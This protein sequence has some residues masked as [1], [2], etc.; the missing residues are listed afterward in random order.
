MASKNFDNPQRIDLDRS[1]AEIFSDHYQSQ[2]DS[3]GL[4]SWEDM[5]DSEKQNFTDIDDFEDE[6]M[7]V[8]HE[9][10]AGVPGYIS[11]WIVQVKRD[12]KQRK[13][14]TINRIIDGLTQNYVKSAFVAMDPSITIGLE[15]LDR[16]Q[17]AAKWVKRKLVGCL[18]HLE[19]I[20]FDR[21]NSELFTKGNIGT[22]TFTSET[23]QLKDMIIDE[24]RSFFK[25]ELNRVKEELE[26]QGGKVK[27]KLSRIADYFVS[28][29]LYLL[30]DEIEVLENMYG[31]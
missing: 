17:D 14:P 28:A 23:V 30:Q 10:T 2:L 8:W 26:K 4:Q 6:R 20:V 18:D 11:D 13:H 25:K 21:V 3:R 5:S 1:V 9:M 29:V 7:D 24:G 27:E 12:V 15:V 19:D 16:V 31:P 22:S